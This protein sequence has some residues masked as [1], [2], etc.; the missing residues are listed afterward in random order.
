MRSGEE[1]RRE[2]GKGKEERNN[3]NTPTTASSDEHRETSG[4][5]ERGGQRECE[6]GEENKGNV[7]VI[8]YRGERRNEM[9]M[10]K[11]AS[12]KVRE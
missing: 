6:R 5:R 12:K 8:G 10:R 2:R 7:W 9:R 4:E 11:A 1:E 3:T